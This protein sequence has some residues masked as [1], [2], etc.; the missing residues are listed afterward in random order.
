MK[1]ISFFIA[2]ATA[3]LISF[4]SFAGD[5]N[6]TKGDTKNETTITV[7]TPNDDPS[8]PPPTSNTYYTLIR[9]STAANPSTAEITSLPTTFYNATLTYGPSNQTSVYKYSAAA[10]Y[11]CALWYLNNPVCTGCRNGSSFYTLGTSV[12]TTRQI[13]TFMCAPVEF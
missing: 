5:G 6:L 10:S 4:H 13:F 8:A 11:S 1:K 3:L 2:S 12:T 9:N 7:A